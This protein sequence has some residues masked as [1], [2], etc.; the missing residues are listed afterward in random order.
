[1]LT[2]HNG[3][4][5]PLGGKSDDSFMGARERGGGGVRGVCHLVTNRYQAGSHPRAVEKSLRKSAVCR[6]THIQIQNRVFRF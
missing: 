3:L 5:P 6:S 2:R 1:M 4:C